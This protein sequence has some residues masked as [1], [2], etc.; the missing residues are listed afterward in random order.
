MASV[1]RYIAAV[2]NSP[3]TLCASQRERYAK[4]ATQRPA[5]GG[6]N[7]GIYVPARFVPAA[8]ER[9]ELRAALESRAQVL[10]E[11]RRELRARVERADR[12]LDRLRQDTHRGGDRAALPRPA[13]RS[14]L[15]AR[16]DRGRRW[17][18]NRAR[19]R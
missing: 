16:A 5:T 11:S 3:H 6:G 7:P 12:E 14:Q 19:G 18:R 8:R 17:S 10:E 4:I 15:A 9:D 2:L 13:T 1:V